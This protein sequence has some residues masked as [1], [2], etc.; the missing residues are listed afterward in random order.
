[1]GNVGALLFVM[2]SSLLAGYE[3]IVVMEPGL[4]L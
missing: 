2:C 4:R 3:V 1:M